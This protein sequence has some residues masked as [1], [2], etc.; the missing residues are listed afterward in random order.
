MYSAEMADRRIV[1]KKILVLHCSKDT[2]L[3]CQLGKLLNIKPERHNMSSG[4]RE[5]DVL[6][7]IR[8]NGVVPVRKSNLLAH[9][10][11]PFSPNQI[12]NW[13]SH[14]NKLM[15]CSTKTLMLY[16]IK[17]LPEHQNQQEI[18]ITDLILTNL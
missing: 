11:N 3:I 16:P 6:T 13:T 12:I 4:Y 9:H 8:Q 18:D 1:G 17:K 10:I 2:P 14:P 5:V 15:L 7:P